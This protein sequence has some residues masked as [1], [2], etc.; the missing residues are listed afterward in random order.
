MKIVIDAEPKE[1]AELLLALEARPEEKVDAKKV[2]QSL[3]KAFSSTLK[4]NS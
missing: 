3:H 1:I 4:V 2:A